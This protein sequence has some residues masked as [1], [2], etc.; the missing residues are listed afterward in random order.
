VA[1]DFPGVV[2]IEESDIGLS[3]EQELLVRRRVDV[4]FGLKELVGSHWLLSA[5]NSHLGRFT[6][7]L[8]FLDIH[9]HYST[10]FKI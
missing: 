2:M 8:Q 5:Y 9:L 7:R 10:I 3:A 4:R 6:S 1:I